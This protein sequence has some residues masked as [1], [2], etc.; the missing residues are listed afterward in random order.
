MYLEV[1]K[2]D[3]ELFGKI[4]ILKELPQEENNLETECLLQ[5]VPIQLQAFSSLQYP[6]CTSW[7]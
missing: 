6:L 3:T 5:D 1:C 7:D 2:S 4:M